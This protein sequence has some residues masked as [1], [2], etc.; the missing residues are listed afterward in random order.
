MKVLTINVHGWLEEN[1]YKKI[2]VLAEVIAKKDYEVIALQE[3]NQLMVNKEISHSRFIKSKNEDNE[4]SLKEENYAGVLIKELEKLGKKY[5]WSWS[6]NHIGYDK[7]DE[8]LSILSKSKQLAETITVSETTD[9]DTIAT[10]NVLKANMKIDGEEWT[11]LNGHFSWWKDKNNNHVFKNEWDK[12]RK[13]LEDIDKDNIIFMGDFNN[14]AE[15]SSGGYDYILKTVPFL[16]DSYTISEKKSGNATMSGGIDGWEEASTD[17]RIDLVFVS[18]NIEV[19]ES[20]VIFNQKNEII[21]SDHFG[22][23]VILNN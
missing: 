21:I 6:A 2:K 1:S 9:Y 8:G 19:K 23:E 20:N 4:I 10:R 11:V 15:L 12:M 22:V 13:H 7:Y 3:V 14:E 18:K 16:R 5:S 17:K